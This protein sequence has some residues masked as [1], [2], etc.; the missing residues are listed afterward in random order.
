MPCSLEVTEY[1]EKLDAEE[2]CVRRFFV[3]VLLVLLLA[4]FLFA[5][6]VM[7]TLYLG[8]GVREDTQAYKNTHLPAKQ[9]DRLR[10]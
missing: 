7:T 8:D 9:L 1:L 2:L 4:C 3:R 6:G 5:F 10:P